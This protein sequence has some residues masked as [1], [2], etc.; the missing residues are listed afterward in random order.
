MSVFVDTSALVAVLD[1]DD[2][3]H[4][5]AKEIWAELVR[6]DEELLS[7]NYVLLETFAVAQRRFGLDAIR[8]LSQDVCPALTVAWVDEST[9][10][11]GVEAVLAEGRRALS[12]VDCVSFELMRRFSLDQVFCFDPH[13]ERA[14]FNTLSPADLR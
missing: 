14:G 2:S 12:L 6:R 13:F 3:H 5:T 10:A 9:H 8:R 11:A 1:S 7:S 4:R